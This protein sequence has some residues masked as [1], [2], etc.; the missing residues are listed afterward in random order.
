M[1]W[2]QDVRRAV[3][4][5]A[6]YMPGEDEAEDQYG[7]DRRAMEDS[8]AA[9]RHPQINPWGS[10]HWDGNT[11]IT[12]LNPWDQYNLDLSRNWQSQIGQGLP[13]LTNAIQQMGMDSSFKLPPVRRPG[14]GNIPDPSQYQDLDRSNLPDF[15]NLDFQQLDFSNL[16]GVNAGVQRSDFRGVNPTQFTQLDLRGMPGVSQSQFQNLDLGGL[17]GVNLG[18]FQNLDLG[19]LQGVNAA[20]ADAG[21]VVDRSGMADKRSGQLAALQAAIAGMPR[22]SGADDFGAESE[23]HLAVGVRPCGEPPVAAARTPAR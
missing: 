13:G 16:P 7:W 5:K 22:L 4:L 21:N 9:N 12:Q 17:Q 23:A 20:G 3:G 6:P 18:S 19:G 15:H 10:M 11:Q 8:M 14:K 2:F 1:S